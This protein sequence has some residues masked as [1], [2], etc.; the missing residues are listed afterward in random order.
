MSLSLPQPTCLILSMTPPDELLMQNTVLLQRSKRWNSAA[1]LYNTAYMYLVAYC[2]NV[3]ASQQHMQRQ[4][5]VASERQS[6]GTH[7]HRTQINFEMFSDTI[8][9]I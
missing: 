5:I 3:A 9:A 6:A 4:H 7:T 1:L 2:S 8:I